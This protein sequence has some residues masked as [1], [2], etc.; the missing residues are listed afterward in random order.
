MD[1]WGALILVGFFLV[2]GLLAFAAFYSR[3]KDK[4]NKRRVWQQ[5]GFTAIEA[6]ALLAE[7]ISSLYQREGIS[8]R[9]ELRNLSRKAILD[10]EMFLFDL[11]ETSGED[12]SWIEQQAVAIVSSYLNLPQFVLFPK[13]DEKYILSGIANRVVEWGMSKIGS[14]VAIS[15]FPGL[16]SRYIITSNDPEAVRRFL[17]ESLSHYLANTQMLRIHAAGD[18]FTS[19]EIISN[20][21][22]SDLE[23]MTQRVDHAMDVFRLF[24]K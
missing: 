19:C 21:K 13:V 7:K 4:E 9:Y 5:L 1:P 8:N 2:F 12:D 10:G 16:D 6:D 15:E 20:S 14:P 17:D 23:N 22:T 18:I 3:R 11:V 24:L